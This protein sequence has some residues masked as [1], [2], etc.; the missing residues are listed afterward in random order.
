MTADADPVI[1][2]AV[3]VAPTQSPVS[4]VMDRDLAAVRTVIEAAGGA[5][6]VQWAAGMVVTSGSRQIVV[7]TD[8]GRGWMPARVVLPADVVLPWEHDDSARWEGLIDPARVIVEYSARQNGELTALASTHSSAPAVAA[9]VPFVYAD[10]TDRAHPEMLSG[11]ISTRIAH[12]DEDLRRKAERTA[13]RPAKEQ[14]VRALGC[15]YRADEEASRLSDGGNLGELRGRI[16]TQLNAQDQA[17]L[18]DLRRMQVQLR[19]LWERL[20]DEYG[21]L[22]QLERAAR[23]DVRDI[24]RGEL[25]MSGGACRPLLAQCY[26]TEAVFGLR[27]PSPAEAL[28]NAVY[29]WGMLSLAEHGLASMTAPPGRANSV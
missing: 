25:D 15:A 19:P 2:P 27:S 1:A 22:R 11:P 8:R 29:S 6:E 3:F 7:T 5:S 17:L 10:A 20:Q 18:H 23:A 24:A 4:P 26:A 14:R 16:L 12:I 28:E 13:G 21:A 9:G